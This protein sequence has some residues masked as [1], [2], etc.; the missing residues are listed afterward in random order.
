M[1][2]KY[3]IILIAIVISLAGIMALGLG[4]N[5]GYPSN[6]VKISIDTNEY[7]TYNSAKNQT[8][9]ID[10]DENH[11]VIEI[12]DGKVKMTEANCPDGYC[13]KQGPITQGNETIVCLPNKLMIEF[14]GKKSSVDT[15]VG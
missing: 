13:L 9:N 3:D 8:I 11:N 15:V 1:L 7:A 10:I 5:L 6:Q 12:E 14:V 4:K 2:N